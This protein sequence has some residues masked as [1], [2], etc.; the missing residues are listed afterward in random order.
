MAPAD[1][2]TRF[3]ANPNPNSNPTI[4][5]TRRPTDRFLAKVV[6]QHSLGGSDHTTPWD[7]YQKLPTLAWFAPSIGLTTDLLYDAVGLTG[8]LAA[9][10]VLAF[11]L[12]VGPLMAMQW[13]LHDARFFSQDF[14][15]EDDYRAR[16]LSILEQ[17]P[18]RGQ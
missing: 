5:G 15:L 7:K 1:P 4:I 6:Q 9:V 13:V 12:P 17:L 11:Q 10:L 8:M 3:L 14:A 18:K 2:P 16:Q